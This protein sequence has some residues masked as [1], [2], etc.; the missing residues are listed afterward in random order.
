MTS[1]V[2][3]RQMTI[4][5][6]ED[7]LIDNTIPARDR[8]YL[9]KLL[10]ECQSVGLIDSW[11]VSTHVEDEWNK[12]AWIGD[13][14]FIYRPGSDGGDP[15]SVYRSDEGSYVLTD[16]D[17]VVAEGATVQEVT[18]QWAWVL[19]PDVKAAIDKRKSADREAAFAAQ[20]AAQNAADEPPDLSE[21]WTPDERTALSQLWAVLRSRGVTLV[22]WTDD[23]GDP[24]VILVDRH[25]DT[26]YMITKASA[27]GY[28]LSVND[29]LDEL[30]HLYSGDSIED[31]V[32]A[33]G[34]PVPRALAAAAE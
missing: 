21:A 29:R 33:T 30:H 34:L 27:G 3:D 11:C 28:A 19:D 23:E 32:K 5:R 31:M 13:D 9:C 7:G 15:L 1:N 22:E 10:D 16:N 12:D 25:G 17:G 14:Y 26:V 20:I 6:T 4:R 8:A 24:N 18:A 2:R